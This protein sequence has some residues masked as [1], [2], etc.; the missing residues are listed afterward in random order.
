ME[1]NCG[2]ENSAF[3]SGEEVVYKIYYNWNFIWS[4]AGLV[5]FNVVE[6]DSSFRVLVT[7]STKGFFDKFYRVRDTFETHLDKETLLPTLFIRKLKEGKYTRYNRFEFDQESKI[8]KVYQGK[9][10]SQLDISEEA[11]SS[12]MHDIL[13]ILYHVRNMDFA[14]LDAGQTF[15]VEVFLEEQYPLHVKILEKDKRKK[16]RG[17]GKFMTHV[18]QPQLIAG[19]V[20]KEK[21][22]M[23]I[24]VSADSNKL[25]VLIESPL[26]VGK[27][28]AVLLGYRGLK[29][30]LS[31]E[32]D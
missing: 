28:K 22:Q 19:E 14:E 11:F 26:S 7:G 23:S 13:S 24:Y 8:V 3:L 29:Y 20:F 25:P 18:F 32:I 1:D 6:S 4:A 17:L 10:T 12:C 5:H 30:D 9:D 15:P 16:V 27:M 21:D 2:I 31:A